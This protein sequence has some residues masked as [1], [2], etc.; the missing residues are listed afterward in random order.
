MALKLSNLEYSNDLGDPIVTSVGN[1]S[2]EDCITIANDA[3][4]SLAANSPY[5]YKISVG[6][7][8]VVDGG[9]FKKTQIPALQIFAYGM[10]S[11]VWATYVCVLQGSDLKTYRCPSTRAEAAEQ[12]V[13]AAE[14][15]AES[16][17]DDQPALNQ[18]L[19]RGITAG[20]AKRPRSSSTTPTLQQRPTSAIPS[21]PYLSTSRT[22]RQVRTCPALPRP[23]AM[24]AASAPT[25]VPPWKPALRSAPAAA[26][27][28][29]NK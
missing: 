13:R 2:I 24:Q 18:L 27:S 17:P 21:R 5:S 10:Q 16:V 26:T 22:R 4:N 15:Q 8:K 11:Q 20:F 1:R 19:N 12:A 9:L 28:L 14:Q 3:L 23:L 7:I 29:L 6:K 25:A